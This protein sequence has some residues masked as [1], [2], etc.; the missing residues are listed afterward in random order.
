[1][2]NF[3]SSPTRNIT[4]HSKES[5]AFHSLLRWKMIVIQILA[6]SLIHFLSNRFR[7]M[8]FLSSGV[9][10]LNRNH[11][12]ILHHLNITCCIVHAW[13]RREE[14][15]LWLKLPEFDSRFSWRS[16]AIGDLRSMK[17]FSERPNTPELSGQ[18][19]IVSLRWGQHRSPERHKIANG[20]PAKSDYGAIS[21]RCL[22]RISPCMWDETGKDE[23]YRAY[24]TIRRSSW[25]SHLRSQQIELF[26]S[27]L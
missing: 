16:E 5:L 3:P 22:V 15:S 23:Q 11:L 13:W 24:T 4:S 20:V 26:M 21:V 14:L 8:Y 25:G 2:S 27:A 10:G 12:L 6:T 9:K 19:K 17:P 18:W 1:M 7:R